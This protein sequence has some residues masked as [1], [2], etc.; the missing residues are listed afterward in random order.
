MEST[1]LD[2]G[3]VE[4]CH[5]PVRTHDQFTVK[6]AVSSWRGSPRAATSPWARRHGWYYEAIRN[7]D[8]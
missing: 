8:P 6:I 3:I 7:G 2:P 4:L 1:D 5:V